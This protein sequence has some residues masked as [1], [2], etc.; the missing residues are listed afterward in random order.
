MTRIYAYAYAIALALILAGVWYYGHTRYEAGVASQQAAITKAQ[1]EAQAYATARDILAQ[2]IGDASRATLDQAL[3]KI[4][5]ETHDSVQKVRVIYRDH[6]VT[7]IRPDG[8]RAQL[9][10]A[11]DRANAAAG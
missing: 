9:E 2:Q 11:R 10:K 7:C 6:P 8:V 1:D 3:P 4:E 5:A